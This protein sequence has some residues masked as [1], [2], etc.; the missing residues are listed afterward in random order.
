MEVMFDPTFTLAFFI[1]GFFV[2]VKGAQLLVSGASSLA[3]LF[4][5]SPWFIGVVLVGI[6]T[7]IPELSIM[8]ASV[9]GGEDLGVAMLIGSSVMN[10]LLILGLASLIRPLSFRREWI[11]IDLPTGIGAL[12][13]A[14]AFLYLPV[15]GNEAGVSR[16]EGAILLV[17]MFAWIAALLRRKST[18]S[19]EVDT[20]VFS[21]FTS[22]L[23]IC[24]GFAGVLLGGIWI[25]DGAGALAAYVGVS[26]S[27]VGLTVLAFGTAIP[28][29]VVTF[30]AAARG[31]MGIAIGNVVGS[32]IFYFLGI[33]GFASLMRPIALPDALA[34]DFAIA[35]AVAI[36]FY[37]FAMFG[38]DRY[39]L[40]RGEGFL[41]VVCY[42][43]YVAFLVVRG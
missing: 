3:R 32:N 15:L 2:L 21:W 18:H 28:N 12:T 13:L 23:F 5:L 37:L 30:V 41:F 17:C 4:G 24:V 38:R 33:F 19:D 6:G 42:L 1:L 25:V 22:F 16:T 35:L 9:R 10:I 36:I 8:T 11:A 43:A 20:R 34:I 27:L 7:S 31:Q 26:P 40:T 39:M 29:F 14:G